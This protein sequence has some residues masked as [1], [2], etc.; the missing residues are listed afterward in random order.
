[1]RE[2]TKNGCVADYVYMSSWAQTC[3]NKL[4]K[5]AATWPA[6]ALDKPGPGHVPPSALSHP[7]MSSDLFNLRL[8]PILATSR[9]IFHQGKNENRA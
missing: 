4:F 8:G 9:R 7:W 6:R 5:M 1:M 3:L 2:N